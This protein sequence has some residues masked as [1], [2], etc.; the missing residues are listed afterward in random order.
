[1][2]LSAAHSNRL[3]EGIVFH[4]LNP[5][6]LVFPAAMETSTEDLLSKVMGEDGDNKASNTQA[7]Y[8]DVDLPEVLQGLRVDRK[9]LLEGME[10]SPLGAIS[11]ADLKAVAERS[12]S[13][14][15]PATSS[16]MSTAHRA[17]IK[18][19]SIPSLLTLH[20]REILRSIGGGELKSH[21]IAAAERKLLVAAE[22]AIDALPLAHSDICFRYSTT[23][24]QAPQE[25][26][27]VAFSCAAFATTSIEVA[28]AGIAAATR[29][30]GTLIII[31]SKKK[32]KQCGEY[33]FVPDADT[34]VFA[35]STRFAALDQTTAVVAAERALGFRP[36]SS[37]AV[38]ALE[39][40]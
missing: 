24:L 6:P 19:L 8:S 23:V 11:I 30:T 28:Y 16:S 25:G 9:A 10:M 29:L 15:A 27:T 40:R 26:M 31:W 36:P 14:D 22:A 34:I 2:L 1:M 4:L 37:L 32:G 13:G 12:T 18:V 39:E 5:E 20:L 7:K 33:V 21:D 3:S 38:W 17:V 35:P